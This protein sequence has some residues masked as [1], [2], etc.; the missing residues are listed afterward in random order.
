MI[1]DTKENFENA[2]LEGK[3]IKHK[4]IFYVDEEPD[5][6]ILRLAP[7]AFAGDT[8]NSFKIGDYDKYK[9]I[10]AGMCN[11]KHIWVNLKDAQE[12]MNWNDAQKYCEELDADCDVWHLPTKE[13]LMLIYVNKYIINEALKKHGGEPM[14]EEWYWSSSEYNS[15][16]AWHQ[17]FSDGY[18]NNYTKNNNYYVRL[19]LAL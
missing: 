3:E 17:R 11:N 12:E 19:V 1:L 6:S 15:V 10:Y 7:V 2:V 16:G 14:K 9:G 18:I 13:E 8:N 5:F 4:T